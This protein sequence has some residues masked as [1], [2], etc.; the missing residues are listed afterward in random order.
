M[1]KGRTCEEERKERTTTKALPRPPQTI[2]PGMGRSFVCVVVDLNDWLDLA[3]SP[4]R[5]G[6]TSLVAH[7]LARALVSV[8]PRMDHA[9]SP[10]LRRAA[11]PR[12]AHERCA[13]E[14]PKSP[15]NIQSF[16]CTRAFEEQPLSTES[17]HGP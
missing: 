14:P 5:R 4:A 1:S 13:P 7:R 11:D 15:P 10:S 16:N 2:K 17:I 9:T 12:S 8:S 6:V 3:I